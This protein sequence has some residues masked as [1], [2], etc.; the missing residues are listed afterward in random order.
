MTLD[1]KT[2]KLQVIQSENEE[3]VENTRL[4]KFIAKSLPDISRSKI[5]YLIKNKFVICNER[6]VC[7]PSYKVKE[8]DELVVEIQKSK[9][10][11]IVAT[12]MKL[13]IVFEDD[14]IAVINKP[15]GL[16]THP[17]A[18]NYDNSLANGLVAHFRSNLS[19]IGG[20]DRPG[21]LHRLDKN[22]SGLLLIAKN[23][24]AHAILAKDLEKRKIKRIY[25]AIIWGT[26][27]KSKD[28]IV[29]N[30]GRHPRDRKKMAVLKDQ[31]HGKEAITHYKLLEVFLRKAFSLIECELETGRTH[32]IRVH[33]SNLG[34]PVVG[35]PDYGNVRQKKY[36]NLSND[37]K[38]HV[39]NI[40]RQM[41]HAKMLRFIHPITK[42]ELQFETNL[43]DD[44]QFLYD[45][46]KRDR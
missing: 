46:L 15:A 8:G 36:Q 38:K 26:V 43:A 23:D 5:Q 21:I 33:L 17:G 9:P 22:T 32:Q 18:G 31:T 27:L 37:I 39:K 42:K 24:Q 44:M 12:E 2:I 3:S 4:D 35:D 25:W 1:N 7:N 19:S 28:T 41:L 40:R 16:V 6:N 13:D 11:D 20:E 10:T 34:Y 14:D 45:M 30:I 29:A